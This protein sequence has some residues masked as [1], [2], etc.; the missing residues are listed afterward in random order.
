MAEKR[1][2]RE[3]E[4]AARMRRFFSAVA[5]RFPDL[6]KELRQADM[7][8]EPAEFV[9]KASMSAAIIALGI[10]LVLFIFFAFAG[11]T[12]AFVLLLLPA[13]LFVSFLY[14]IKYP[15]VRAMRRRKEID[16]DLVFAGRHMLIE[17]KAGV[18]LFDAMASITQ[19]YGEVS[20]EFNRI[21]EKIGV[22]SSM[23]IAMHD[24]AEVNP[25]PSFNRV[26]IQLTNSI[27]SGS[28]VTNALEIVLDQISREQAIEL[29]SYG[30]KLNPLA[31]FYMM[32]GI[33]MP[34]L[35]VSLLIVLLSF[36]NIKV[37]GELLLF[38]A[39][40]QLALQYVF[41]TMIESSRPMF[42]V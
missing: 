34:S 6:R 35:G 16:K 29:K 20:K 12:P 19:D 30:Q 33:I 24:I 28:D 26:V 27:R 32:T 7:D 31:M 40:A 3:G 21:V 18:P 25:S 10:S 36:V 1:R 42:F 11:A 23:D 13:V 17:L 5:A 8:E 14:A 41:L 22:G 2:R 15:S 39:I 37:G 4:F 38:A 9:A